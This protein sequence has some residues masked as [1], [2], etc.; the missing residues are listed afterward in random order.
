MRC[1]E[2]LLNRRRPKMKS[3]GGAAFV[4]ITLLAACGASKPA[5]S[6]QA[7]KADRLSQVN[8]S[9]VEFRVTATPDRVSAGRVLFKVHNDGEAPVHEFLVVRTDLTIP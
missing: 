8:V 9:L 2:S 7:G 5:V 6:Q 1:S 3:S 4:A